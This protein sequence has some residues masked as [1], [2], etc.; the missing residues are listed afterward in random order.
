MRD[1]L[2]NISKTSDTILHGDLTLKLRQ[3]FGKGKVLNSLTE[4]EL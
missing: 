2:L 3:K 1:I 4:T